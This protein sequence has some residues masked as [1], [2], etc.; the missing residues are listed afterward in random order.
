VGVLLSW[1]GKLDSA[2]VYLARARAEDSADVEIR[3]VQARV[4]AWDKQY[5]A[6][7]VRYDSLL[8]EHPGLHE[9][10][11][12]RARTLAWAGRLD[13][14]RTLYRQLIAADSTD[15]DAMLGAA[16][17][18]AWKGELDTAEQEYRR[19]LSRN[20]RDLEA[21]VG[22][23]YVYF[24]QGRI[25]AAGR[26]AAYALAIDSTDKSAREL[27]QSV[28]EASGS[29]LEPSANWSDD[30]DGNTNFWQSLGA[31]APLGDR[32]RMFGSVNGLQAS[33]PLRHGRRVGAEGG[34]TISV[35][36]VQLTG[37]AGARHLTPELAPSR[38]A[39]TYRGQISYRPIPRLGLSLGYSRL[40]F[41][42]TAVLIERGL[43]LE[44]L[45][46]GIDVRPTAAL[47]VFGGVGALRLS[48]GNSQSNFSAGVTQKFH[49][50]FFGGVL[51]RTLSYERGGIGYFSPDRF[52]LLEAIAGYTHETRRWIAGLSGGLGAQQIGARGA[53]QTEWRGE[54]R[55]GRRWDSGNRLEL[56]GLYTNSAVS[57]TTG[58]FRYGSI[59]MSA[60]LSL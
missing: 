44:S 3:L 10:A 5:S 9:A 45:E 13:D 32:V 20:G 22:L 48:D 4:L 28:R 11:L 1:Q 50:R 31:S 37:A 8:G 12:G 16:Q 21:R 55:L 29:A 41:D 26:Q 27:R 43:D 36:Q 47:T 39:A 40:P 49:Q 38:T 2:L 34:A 42:E 17:V 23:G 15:R 24:W 19:L 52:S 59:G 6:A 60:R 18:G 46:G 51:G 25:S 30:S 33:D 53:A 35:G 56:F 54:G 7:L 57:S 58:A 14:S